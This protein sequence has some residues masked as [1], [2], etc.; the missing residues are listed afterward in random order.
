MD[1]LS[2]LDELR[3]HAQNGLRY[4]DDPY[5]E[6]RYGRILELVAEGY[7]GAL[8]LPAEEARER[9][10][11]DL[12]HVTPNVG[13]DAAVFDEEGRVLLIERADEG[14][15]SLPCGYVDPG[16]SPAE[17]AVRETR[18]ETG[19]EVRVTELVGV[20][21]RPPSVGTNPHGHVIV[22]YLCERTGGEPA[23][24]RESEA[25]AYRDPEA[26]TD[27]HHGHEALVSDATELRS[28]R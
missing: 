6:R 18:E 24:S 10:R 7:G 3:V 28:D 16:E 4:A 17:T 19:I 14:T 23:T 1:L 20:Y 21:R 12:G 5:D 9:L 26:V 11:R 25:V 22:C 2:L 8:D 13:S 27:W 15:W